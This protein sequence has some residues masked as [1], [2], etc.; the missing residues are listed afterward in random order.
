VLFLFIFSGIEFARVNMIRNSIENAA[1]EGA[2]TGIIPGATAA[3]CEAA[4]Q[5]MLD[6]LGLTQTTVTVTPAVIQPSTEAVTVSVDVPIT[7]ANGYIT[8]RFYLG[9]TLSTSITLGR[10]GV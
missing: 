4:A 6:T 8:P 3:Q 10:E 2:R 5:E 9:A 7:T 1:Y